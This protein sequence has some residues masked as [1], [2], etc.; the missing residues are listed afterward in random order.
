MSECGL[1]DLVNSNNLELKS[2]FPSDVSS[3]GCAPWNEKL[4]ALCN[5]SAEEYAN[6]VLHS[7]SLVEEASASRK[8][9]AAKFRGCEVLSSPSKI[10]M[11]KKCRT[12]AAR[13]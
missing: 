5:V 3:P 4:L 13:V 7:A 11:K 1:G 12:M 8:K 9:R 2:D 10:L 6:R